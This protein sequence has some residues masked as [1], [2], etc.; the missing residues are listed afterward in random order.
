M[1]NSE[2]CSVGAEVQYAPRLAG[3]NLQ[4]VFN[5]SFF[6]APVWNKTPLKVVSL[7]WVWQY[8]TMMYRLM[9]NDPDRCADLITKTQTL[10]CIADSEGQRQFKGRNFDYIT[11]GGTFTYCDDKSLVK[12]SGMVCIDFDHLDDDS[13]KMKSKISPEELK[14][15]LLHDPYFGDKTLM[16]FDSPRGHG[17]KWFVEVDMQQCDYKTWYMALRNYL[18]NAYGLGDKQVDSSVANVSHACFLSFDPKAYL[19]SDLYEFN[20]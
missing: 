11:P 16:Y 12:A 6:K 2:K 18:M 9:G 13:P 3:D 10:R 8:V 15:L 14:E 20:I 5:V 17:S 7:F 1:V 4:S 19:R